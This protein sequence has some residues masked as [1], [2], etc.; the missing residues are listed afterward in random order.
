MKKNIANYIF[1]AIFMLVLVV[2]FATMNFKPNQT[3]DI[4]NKILA[5]FPEITPSTETV[6]GLEQY[7]DD[8]VGFREEAIGFYTTAVDK[9]FGVMIHPL[10]MYG[11]DGHIFYK[12]PDYIAAYQRLNT[13][14]EYLGSLTD[15]LVKTDEYLKEKNIKFLYFLCPDKKTIYSEYFPDSIH[16][17]QDEKTVISVMKDN[18]NKTGVEYVIPDEELLE[19]KKSQVVYN[20]MYDATHWNEFGSMLG[21]KKLDEHIQQWFSDV[22]P[23]TE[24]DFTLDY[25]NM[26]NLD[27][28]DFPINDE[29]PV[30][31]LKEDTAQEATYYLEPYLDIN[32]TTFYSHYINPAVTNGKILLVF[33]DSYFA[34]YHKYYNNR[35]SEVYYVHRQN[36]DFLQYMVDLVMPSVVIFETAERSITSEMP[37]LSDFED[38]CYEEPYKRD[39][40][41]KATEEENEAL[42]IS[43]IITS[44][45][46]V[47]VTGNKISINPESPEM[48]INVK[49]IIGDPEKFKNF[50]IYIEAGGEYLETDYCAL[51]REGD[52]LGYK[53]F[54]FSIQRRYF[55]P[56][57]LN[58][59]AVDKENNIEYLIDTFEVEYAVQ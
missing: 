42:G 46:G 16:V 20:K 9:I 3:S 17:K 40:Y 4:D 23:L 57:P 48:I 30:Y 37:I 52:L 51:K 15:F 47:S 13:D 6:E 27:T 59:I 26:T 34:T 14:E 2:P 7:V 41:T 44:S 18:L 31:T 36:F 12:D 45:K 10:F 49:G 43:Y 32:T 5:E 35:F 29:V 21:Q 33:T 19:A 55:V 11:K 1:I 53:Q 25:V 22:K 28:S 39:T 38:V 50:D 8:R 54:S 58:L 56:M 24:D